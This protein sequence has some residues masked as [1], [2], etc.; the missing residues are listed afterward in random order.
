[1]HIESPVR[2]SWSLTDRKTDQEVSNRRVI[3]DIPAL[4]PCF[5]YPKF[6]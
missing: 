5:V 1:M 3:N 4:F 6:M 2:K